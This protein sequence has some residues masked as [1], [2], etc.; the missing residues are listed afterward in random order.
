MKTSFAVLLVA[1]IIIM[2]LANKKPPENPAVI[3]QSD[4][5]FVVIYTTG[6]KWDASKSPYD[7]AYFNDH[8]AFMSKLRKDAVT[9]LGARYSDKGMLVIKA[10]DLQSAQEL[11]TG[12]KAV[13]NG[14]FN[15]EVHPANFFYT[16]CVR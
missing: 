6:Q 9:L 3:V 12:D 4:S 7:Q 10:A 8:S 14:T 15:A 1:G 13:S 2:L 5:L 11:I 16:G